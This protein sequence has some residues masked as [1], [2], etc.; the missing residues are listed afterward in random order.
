MARTPVRPRL[1][2]LESRT[3]PANLRITGLTLVDGAG[4]PITST[5]IG[6]QIYLKA[7]WN[8]SSLSASDQYKVR[9]TF[10]GRDYDSGLITPSGAS[11]SN[12]RTQKTW[13]AVASPRRLHG[14]CTTHSDAINSELFAFIRS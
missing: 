10:R 1:E 4:N 12:D 7:D 13:L 3:A 14:V 8:Y 11:G 6:E 9:Q 5:P 2:T